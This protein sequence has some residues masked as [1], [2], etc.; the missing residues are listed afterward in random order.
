M[1]LLRVIAQLD[2][3]MLQEITPPAM[4]RSRTT[5]HQAIATPAN[6]GPTRGIRHE[7]LL[8]ITPIS[9]NLGGDDRAFA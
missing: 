8:T 9:A 3:S 6:D 4:C 1:V 7:P 2:V 5:A